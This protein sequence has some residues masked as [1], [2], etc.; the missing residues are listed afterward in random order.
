MIKFFTAITIIFLF[1]SASLPAAEQPE[2][3]KKMNFMVGE[4]E[5][6]SVKQETGMKSTG[7]SSIR[8]G[9][10]GKWLLWKFSALLEKGPIE[11]L[12]LINYH[13][14]KKQF[15]FYSFNPYDDEPLPHYGNWIDA[16]T[17]RLEIATRDKKV[18]VKFKIKE[19]GDFLQEHSILNPSG[20]WEITR[21]TNY[22]KK[23]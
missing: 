10:G 12:T 23:K 11:V 4:W 20:K 8:W 1:L 5:S 6:V 3:L 19:N 17:F 13:N 9:I 22:S 18:R 21:R 15:V 7:N 16:S 14:E 2:N